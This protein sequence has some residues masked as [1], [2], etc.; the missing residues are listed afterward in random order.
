MLY[1]ARQIPFDPRDFARHESLQRIAAFVKGA[2]AAVR[3][4]AIDYVVTA[5][6]F[7]TDQ[8]TKS[9]LY[10]ASLN[11]P[12]RNVAGN[13]RIG[14][15]AFEQDLAWLAG[16]VFHEL[17]HSPQHA[18]YKAKGVTRIDPSRSEIERR[19]IALDEYEAYSWSLKRSVE[20]AL[21]EAQQ[22][23]IRRRANFALIDVDDPKAKS[24]AHGQQFNAARDELIRQYSPS[25]AGARA[26]I[27]RRNSSACCTV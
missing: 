27:T 8:T 2:D 19:M 1:S 26:P 17:V 5:H 7:S 3:Q 18:Y 25:S 16:V 20:L 22:S 23:E 4:I 24:L 14:P 15:Q 10:E 11:Q 12:G 13:I 21:S 9:L 6:A